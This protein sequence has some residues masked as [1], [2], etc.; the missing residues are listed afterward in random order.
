MF[1]ISLNRIHDK[2]KIKEGDESLVLKVD[3]DP[4]R[5]VAGCMQ[6]QKVLQAI[7][8]NSSEEQRRNAAMYFAEVI[9]GPKQAEE[10][11]DFYHNDTACLINVCGKYFSERL[12]KLIDK[13]QRKAGLK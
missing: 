5:M 7:D 2:V 8:D 10:L 12:S 4:L 3:A 11:R 6:A 1:E 9:F 13:A